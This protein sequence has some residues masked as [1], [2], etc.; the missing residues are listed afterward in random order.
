MASTSKSPAAPGLRA[1]VATVDITNTDAG[2][3]NDPLYAKAL[4][5]SDGAVTVVLA[6]VD[7]VAIAEI[8]SIRNEFL[9]NVRAQL[10]VEPGLEPEHIVINASHCHGSVCSDVEQRIVRVVKEACQNM[11]PVTA[12]AGVGHEDR[13]ME[14]RRVKLK[15]GRE[16]DVRQA[17]SLVDDAEVEAV[18]P[19]DPEIGVLRLD[20]EDGRTLAVVY[21]FACHPILGVPSGGNTAD[22]SGFASRAIEDNLSDGTVAL[23]LQ[24]CA[25]DVNP[26][27]YKMVDHLRGGESL[28]NMLGLSTLRALRGIRSR[29]GA[30][31]KIVRETM[32]LPRA[33]LRH[34]IDAL[35]AE[36]AQLLR[37]LKGININL[38]TFISLYV[39]YHLAPNSPSHYS[40]RYM[41]EEMMGRTDLARL[42]EDNRRSIDT[43][44]D[45]IYAME[46]L[47]RIRINMDLL[48]K[49]QAR[50]EDSGSDTI[51][52]EVV[53]VRI[54]DFVL[55]TFPG[56]LSVQI[57]LNIKKRSPHEL[58]FVAGVTNGYIYYTPTA[59][60]LEN[61]GRAQEDS[62][63]L[64]APEWQMLFEDKAADILER[65]A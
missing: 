43:Y 14:N 5:V 30:G 32:A 61:V 8:G 25:G 52:V 39:K 49:H 7:A 6:T 40:Y 65:L 10:Q 15:D 54:G 55:I 63:C 48:K 24:G 35:E 31:L 11:V 50:R 57:G 3:V 23:F 60:Q 59:E 33:D 41:H 62:D 58:T 46:Q 28:G 47:T 9:A 1:G 2:P 34:R 64:V 22:I 16:A 36:Q 38:K 45:N 56:E 17:Y 51:E 21:N 12:G 18:G 20:R 53:G 27:Y 4:A 44:I 19:V 37:S 29:E 13:I 26:A 42:D